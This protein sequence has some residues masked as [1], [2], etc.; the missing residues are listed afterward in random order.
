MICWSIFDWFWVD[1][2]VE[3]RAKI[4]QRIRCVFTS[5]LAY[6]FD[7]AWMDFASNSENLGMF[8]HDTGKTMI[9]WFSQPLSWNLL[10]FQGS[11]LQKSLKINFRESKTNSMLKKI[12][13]DVEWCTK[14]E[15]SLNFEI[16]WKFSFLAFFFFI[17]SNFFC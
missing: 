16:F 1:L 4:D 13:N 7:G 3:N 14:I 9:S 10:S 5:S 15:I 12:K 17:F 2:G 8:L 6:I 11:N